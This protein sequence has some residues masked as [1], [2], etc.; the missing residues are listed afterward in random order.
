MRIAAAVGQGVPALSKVD[1]KARG[2]EVK[3]AIEQAFLKYHPGARDVRVSIPKGATSDYE[4]QMHYQS[5]SGHITARLADGTKVGQSASYM[6]Q[7]KQVIMRQPDKGPAIPPAKPGLSVAANP[8][9]EAAATKAIEQALKAKYPTARDVQI[10]FPEWNGAAATSPFAVASHYGSVGARIRA[11]LG[12]GQQLREGALY[13]AGK[14]LAL[15]E[16]LPATAQIAAPR[17]RAPAQA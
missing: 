8:R 2:E 9:L 11:T 6:L 14:K 1:N 13:V 4:A 15:L 17:S 3:K 5:V 10:S 7:S 16:P 12:N